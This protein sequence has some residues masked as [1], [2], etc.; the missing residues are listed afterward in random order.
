[1]A[2]S[3]L[4]VN[5]ERCT[6][7]WSCAVGC[8]MVNE[9][10]DDVFRITVK[11]HGSGA[12]TDR[13]AGVWPNLSM[14][15]Q[16]VW[17]RQCTDCAEG[18]ADHGMFCVYTCPSRALTCG[19]AADAEMARL[20]GAGFETFQIPAEE[21][22]RKNVWYARRTEKL[23]KP[24]AWERYDIVEKP[25]VADDGA[26]RP[27]LAGTPISE[28]AEHPETAALLQ[29]YLPWLDLATPEGAQSAGLPLALLAQFSQGLLSEETLE[30]IQVEFDALSLGE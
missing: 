27:T 15:W 11:T 12:G 23:P 18:N 1:M 29:K 5:L 24:G 4:L 28:L 3:K 10:A 30:A 22:T 16:P 2:Y 13:P 19:D 25:F 17:S 26:F 21:G 20:E 7:C 9:L 14:D 8:K 6:G